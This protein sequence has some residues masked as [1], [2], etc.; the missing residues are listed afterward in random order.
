MKAIYL[1]PDNCF[2]LIAHRLP[3]DCYVNQLRGLSIAHSVLETELAAS[4]NAIVATVWDDSLRKLSLLEED[5]RF[6]EPRVIPDDKAVVD[7]A[8]A[9]AEKFRLRRIEQPETLLGGRYVFGGSTPG[10]CMHRPD[11]SKTFHL[12]R[13]NGCRYY[14]CYNDDVKQQWVQFSTAMKNAL[15]DTSLH[16]SIIDAAHE[17]FSG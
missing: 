11:V 5:L 7:A 12:A 10:N 15:A 14:A 13:L 3:V 2:C 1:Y 16:D 17:T 9:M 8:L 4:D 6:F